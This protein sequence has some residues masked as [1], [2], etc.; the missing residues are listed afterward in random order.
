MND[1]LGA[2]RA[3][4]KRRDILLSIQ[5]K[6]NKH[7]IVSSSFWIFVYLAGSLLGY[8]ILQLLSDKPI[9]IAIP[10]LVFLITI[11][12]IPPVTKHPTYI[13][14][15]KEL[16]FMKNYYDDNLYD[17]SGKEYIK[18]IFRDTIQHELDIINKRV[19]S[20]REKYFYG[21]LDCELYEYIQILDRIT[22]I[23]SKKKLT[24]RLLNFLNKQVPES[25][26][27]DGTL[28]SNY[29]ILAG[30]SISSHPVAIFTIDDLTRIKSDSYLCERFKLAL[31]NNKMNVNESF[32]NDVIT[33]LTRL[34]GDIELA[35]KGALEFRKRI[36]KEKH[37]DFVNSL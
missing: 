6:L 36:N 26:P 5:K 3:G 24:N 31:I 13:L 33:Y 9:N 1:I 18:G 10:I 2:I 37:L 28:I 15:N 12:V 4:Y 25:C 30:A 19:G 21:W 34:D 32:K 14:D 20:L 11:M 16:D 8:L 35:T 17:E 29:P 23:E 22:K 7:Y 27:L